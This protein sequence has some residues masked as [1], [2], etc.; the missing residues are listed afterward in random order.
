M[1]L[2]S[3]IKVL[4]L[5]KQLAPN[6]II[7][8]QA[9]EI[10][11]INEIHKVVTGDLTFVDVEK[12][13]QKA[14]NSAASVILINQAIEPPTGKTL[15]IIAEPFEAYNKLIRQ[16]RPFRPLN[17]LLS[18]TSLVHPSTILEPNV[19][20]GNHVKI[21]KN[22]YIQAN[23]TIRDY[24]IIGDNVTIES[25][26]IIGADAF[27]YK[28]TENGYKKWRSGGRTVIQ[29]SVGIGAGCTICKGVSGDTI[30]GAG[31]KLDS[32]VHIG[33]GVV[34][35]QNC[36]MAAQVGIGGKTIIGDNVIL[37]GQVGVAARLTI[38]DNI[39][40]LAKSGVTKNLK[41]DRNYFGYPAGEVKR[42]YKELAALRSLP[43][44]LKKWYKKKE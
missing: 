30:I 44:L 24:T 42:M 36:L 39:T 5:A 16:Y 17:A 19:I 43:D 40:V 11:G 13:Y 32:Q 20:I 9:F 33:H 28:P 23:V 21:G 25:G 31:T 12:Y 7:G 35:G 6:K 1:K 10:T 4:D 2:P 37:Y 34:I 26:T 8:N 3:P 29:D 14:L 18:E 27:Y 15:I 41:A 22:C 38:G